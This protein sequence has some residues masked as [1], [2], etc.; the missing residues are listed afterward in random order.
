[1]VKGT[2]VSVYVVIAVFTLAIATVCAGQ[3]P[4]SPAGGEVHSVRELIGKGQYAE[5]ITAVDNALKS[6]PKDPDL[7]L[8]KIDALLGLHRS[9]QARRLALANLSLGPAFRF[10]AGKCSASV[11]RVKE[12][13]RF[14]APLLKDPKWAGAACE[15]S[16]VGLL[17][18]GKETEARELLHRGIKVSPDARPG[19][20]ALAVRLD[21]NATQVKNYKAKTASGEAG[22]LERILTAADGSLFGESLD[23]KLPA[24]IKLKEKSER[25]EIPSL[26]WGAGGRGSSSASGPGSEM[27]IHSGST[28]YGSGLKDTTSTEGTKTGTVSAAPRPVVEAYL[29]GGGKEYMVLDSASTNVLLTPKVAKKLDLKPMAPGN[30]SAI[31]MPSPVPSQWVL[32]SKMKVGDLTFTNVPALLISQEAMFWKE[33]AGVIPLWMFRHYALHYD[34]RHS[35]LTLYPPGT[36]ATS[37][38]GQGAFPLKCLWYGNRLYVESRIQNHPFC[39]LQMATANSGSYVEERRTGDLGLELATARHGPQKEQA[40]FSI[41]NSGVA[42]NL[43]LDLGTTRINLR[44]ILVADLCPDGQIDCYGLIGRNILDL[45]DVFV[46]YESGVVALKGYEKGR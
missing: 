32:I 34:R 1:M 46:D 42:E 45:F 7:L 24:Q 10:K 13:L 14:W 40:L 5:A 29:N 44:T 16:V 2:A 30:Y 39:Y 38:L 21:G 36:S 15:E 17:A 8:C 12:A 28:S 35:R 31:G 25:I 41:I 11:G 22:S 20:W 3:A 23:G 37:V 18:L 4:S 27:D 9:V 6:A 43:T 26:R 33:T 19:L